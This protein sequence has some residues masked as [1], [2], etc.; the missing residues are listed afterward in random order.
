MLINVNKSIDTNP[1]LE[2]YTPNSNKNTKE[3]N[4][5]DTAALD[6]AYGTEYAK[7]SLDSKEC[8]VE[9]VSSDTLN[10]IYREVASQYGQELAEKYALDA[11]DNAEQE[12]GYDIVEAEKAFR[13]EASADNLM[14]LIKAHAAYSDT[15]AATLYSS[16][17]EE[18]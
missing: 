4:M 18:L 1:W 11:S 12:A 8:D 14:T 6:I 15:Y 3:N 13:K 7:L 10:S 16:I 5:I 17:Q 2:Q 9:Q